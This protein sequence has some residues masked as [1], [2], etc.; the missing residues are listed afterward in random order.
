MSI[1][2]TH[3]VIEHFWDLWNRSK[4]KKIL[5]YFIFNSMLLLIMMCADL[6]FFL[7]ILAAH[8]SF[9]CC[10]L[11]DSFTFKHVAIQFF[12]SYY[13]FLLRSFAQC[14]LLLG[15]FSFFYVHRKFYEKK[16]DSSIDT[17]KW[18]SSRNSNEIH[19][20][21]LASRDVWDVSTTTDS[22]FCIGTDKYQGNKP[23]KRHDVN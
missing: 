14:T 11:E 3:E 18:K 8:F 20:D 6:A 1:K 9:F 2:C 22:V 4:Q 21:Y 10:N 5:F 16:D 12:F 23:G 13:F 7:L 19:A 17:S 15:K